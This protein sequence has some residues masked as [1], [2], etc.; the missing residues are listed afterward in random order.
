MRSEKF[1]GKAMLAVTCALFLSTMLPVSSAFSDETADAKVETAGERAHF[2][3]AFCKVSPERVEAYKA[4]LRNRLPD[5]TDF[6][7]RWQAGWT[8]A[9]RP[10][11]DMTALRE[12][13][14]D[15]FAARIK[16]NCERLRWMAQ[17]SL[18]AHPTK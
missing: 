3:E 11:I 12:H 6:D 16:V 18:R 14:P 7:E 9:R 15:Q 13:D 17:N 4:Q 2:A 5:V 10:V 1:R 8:R